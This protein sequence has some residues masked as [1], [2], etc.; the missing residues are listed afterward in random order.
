VPVVLS[1][2][3]MPDTGWL[4]N[5]ADS[6]TFKIRED[7][8]SHSWVTLNR[9]SRGG[10]SV[11]VV[12]RQALSRLDLDNPAGLPVDHVRPIRDEIDRRVQALLAEL[13]DEIPSGS[14]ETADACRRPK[15]DADQDA[16]SEFSVEVSCLRH[17]TNHAPTIPTAPNPAPVGPLSPVM[18]HLLTCLGIPRLARAGAI[19]SV[20]CGSLAADHLR[21]LRGQRFRPFPL[22]LTTDP[23]PTDTSKA[24]I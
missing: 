13:A 21:I 3:A 12:P 2:T 9:S 20:L 17:T 14:G 24:T 4:V 7:A 8:T 15:P 18:A 19:F 1:T 23:A 6:T 16:P 11:S 22:F 10:R 5:L